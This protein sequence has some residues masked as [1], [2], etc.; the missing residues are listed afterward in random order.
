MA[1]VHVGR[2]TLQVKEK[3]TRREFVERLIGQIEE[4]VRQVVARCIEEALEA[5]VNTLLKRGWYERRKPR[6]RRRSG[7]RCRQ[8]G[9]QDPQ[10]F[11]R[12]GHYQRYL[13]THWGRLRI[14]VP[15]VECMCEGWVQVPFKTLRS[16]QRIWD[17]L[18][19]EIR[20]RYGWGMSLR[21]IKEC[22][23]ARLSSSVSLRTLN[24]CVR[25]L[26][27]LVVPWQEQ[28]VDTVPPVVRV[29]GI[30]VTL[31]MHTGEVRRDRIGRQRSVKQAH[32]VP[33]LVAQGVWPASG[34]QEIVAWVLGG[35]EDEA[36]WEALLTQMWE[37]GIEPERGLC[38]LVADGAAGLEAA[39]RTV[40]WEVAFQRCI[41]H[42][43]RNIWRD[44]LL[45]E[46]LEGK[47]A[48]A[49]K[50]RFIRS[51]ARIWQAPDEKQ[52][53]RRQCQFCRKW[54]ADQPTAVATL[55][56]DFDATLTFYRLQ[57]AAAQ[58]G[59]LWPARRLRT[60]SPLEREFR[61]CRRRLAG[62]VLFHSPAG[63]AA[64]LHQ[65]LVRRTASRANALPRHWHLSLERALADVAGFS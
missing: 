56:R 40:Y 25:E 27:Q 10:D 23:D 32:K 17:D 54:E 61:T 52:A 6:R 9:S 30:W 49:Y 48:Q 16:R 47:T 55:Q 5:E 24:R 65:W 15:Q 53:R 19:G 41:F 21:W 33:V 38:L 60:N 11:R 7:A 4:H 3:G 57:A 22:I 50:R 39:R 36:S 31:M 51:A 44:I 12:D 45:P 1:I 63:L 58:R 2:L 14:N 28:L 62:A 13:D 26:A 43:L 37:R 29:D 34:R 18:E 20:E 8:C 42:K 35:A 64:M 59:Q 46:G